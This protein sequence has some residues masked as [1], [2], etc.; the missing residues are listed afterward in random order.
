MRQKLIV[1]SAVFLFFSL[2]FIAGDFKAEA[3]SE[4]PNSAGIVKVS[5]GKLNVRSSASTSSQIISTLSNGTNISIINE[6]GNFYK[7]QYA[8]GKTGYCHKDYVSKIAGSY[9]AYVNTSSTGLNV[10]SGPSTSYSVKDL[11]SK[12]ENVVVLSSHGSFVKILYKGTSVGY[13]SAQYIKKPISDNSS[14]TITLNVPSFKQYD[15]RWSSVRLGNSSRTIA[16]SGCLTT[17]IAMDRS[18]YKGYTVRPDSVART[19]KYTSGGSLYWPNGYVFIYG[20]DLTKFRDLI[21]DNTPVLVGAKN[22]YGSQ[23]WVIIKGYRKNGTVTADDF[24]INDPGSNSR[25]TLS[26]FYSAFPLFYKAAYRT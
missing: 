18:F 17:A 16:Q 13:T 7:V 9:G 8:P 25:T 22:S 20:N 23:H 2:L 6:N 10:R 26:S 15:S 21:L 1:F 24:I 3:Y 14:N 11:L 12:G 4:A 19:E 5:Y